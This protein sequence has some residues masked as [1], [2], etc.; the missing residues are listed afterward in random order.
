MKAKSSSW[1]DVKDIVEGRPAERTLVGHGISSGWSGGELHV[2]FGGEQEVET[3][4]I[5]FKDPE[6]ARKMYCKGI[7]ME[8][9]VVADP[10]HEVKP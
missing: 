2:H 8:I 5:R 4:Q 6:M 3:V 1:E 7:R 10:R 9:K